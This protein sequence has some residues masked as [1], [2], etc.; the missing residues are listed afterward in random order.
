[1]KIS[2]SKDIPRL[3]REN[4]AWFIRR[5]SRVGLQVKELAAGRGE[6]KI[7]LLFEWNDDSVSVSV[8]GE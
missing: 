1:M 7:V 8:K 2:F 4:L 3:R 5:A 6:E